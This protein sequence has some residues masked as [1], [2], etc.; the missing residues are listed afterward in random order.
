MKIL[1]L[2]PYPTGQAPG[3]RYRIEQWAPY[4][5][6][7]GVE[8]EFAPFASPELAGLLYR[9]GSVLAKAHLMMRRTVL[10]ARDAWS[11]SRFDAVLVH[12]EA[13]LVGPAWAERLARRRRPV[14]IYDFDDAV[15]VPYVSPTNRYLSYLKCPGKT[16]AICRMASAVLAGNEHLAQWAKQYCGN[17]HVVPSTV[18]LRE[19]RGR[20]AHARSGEAV[21]GWTGS[22]SSVQYLRLIEAPLVRLRRKQRF[23]MVLVGV[24]GV[25]MPGIDVECRPWS[26]TTEV[27]DLWDFDVGIMPLPDE[28]WA[29][30]KCGMKAIQYMAIGAPAVVSPIGANRTIV[31]DGIDGYHA[32]TDDEWVNRLERLLL[33]AELRGKLGSAARASV[34]AHYS[35]EAHAPRVA[36]VLKALIERRSGSRGLTV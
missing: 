4:L 30:G 25:T 36:A 35:A 3:Q 28:P 15:W 26:A 9:P 27:Q 24:S 1:A 22:H 34:E 11:A 8:I 33:D 14:L 20:P 21:I 19:Y 10:R 5:L 32:A 23:R 17:V 7:H 6:E 29:R 13:C 12:R 18:A 2:V 31:R 16:R